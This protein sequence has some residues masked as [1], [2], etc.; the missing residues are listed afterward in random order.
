MTYERRKKW[1]RAA[2]LGAAL[3]LSAPNAHA[4]MPEKG[5]Y[6]TTYKGTTTDGTKIRIDECVA[7]P[8]QKPGEY[9]SYYDS[10]TVV[11][12]NGV[13]TETLDSTRTRCGDSYIQFKE[14]NNTVHIWERRLCKGGFRTLLDG[15]PVTADR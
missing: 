9:K 12:I 3:A 8:E 13:Q 10:C 6:K 5:E 4:V 2:G 11:F 1:V 15:K 14:K 7:W